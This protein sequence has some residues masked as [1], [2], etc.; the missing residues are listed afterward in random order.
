M[1][2]EVA[3]DKRLVFLKQGTSGLFL[4]PSPKWPLEPILALDSKAIA[5]W[6]STPSSAYFGIS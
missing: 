4:N 2:L 3:E 5:L 6:F 1:Q